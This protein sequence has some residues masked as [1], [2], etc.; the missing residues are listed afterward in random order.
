MKRVYIGHIRRCPFFE[1]YF[2]K[3]FE[4]FITVF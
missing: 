3:K 1:K 4:K 2:F